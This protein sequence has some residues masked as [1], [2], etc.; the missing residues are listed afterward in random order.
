MSAEEKQPYVDMANEAKEKFNKEKK[1]KIQK[2][3]KTLTVYTAWMK[4]WDPVYRKEHPEATF[5]DL[6]KVRSTEW[7][8]IKETDKI[9]KY[10]KMVE[11]DKVRFEK[12]KA[13]F[14]AAGGDM[15]YGKKKKTKKDV[16]HELPPAELMT[17]DDDDEEVELTAFNITDFIST[18]ELTKPYTQLLIDVKSKKIYDIGSEEDDGAVEYGNV[19][20]VEVDEDGDVVN[21]EGI[22]FI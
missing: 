14:I 20:K 12:E 4:E 2:P 13:A 8:K 1:E 18:T 5:G 21:I 10:K 19:D 9:Q 17:D 11:E 15:S 3:K 7:K 22:H 16:I 6:A